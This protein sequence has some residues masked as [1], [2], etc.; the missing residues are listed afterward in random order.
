MLTALVVL[1]LIG[2]G[3]LLL[4]M[5]PASY[6]AAFGKVLRR[7]DPMRL[8]VL[9]VSVVMIG[10]CTRRLVIPDEE[11]SLQALYLLNLAVIV[12]IGLLTR[13]YGRGPRV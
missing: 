7:G 9:T 12:H 8:S 5:L 6:N 3:G 13:A 2:W 4:W 1:N 10:F 11:L